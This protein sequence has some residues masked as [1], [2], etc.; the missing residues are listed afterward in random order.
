[1]IRLELAL[2]SKRRRGQPTIQLEFEDE[3][4]DHAGPICLRLAKPWLESGRALGADSHFM[5]VESCT[6]MTDYV[7]GPSAHMPNA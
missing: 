3:Y 1:M 5:S 7:R 6:A 4:H 2:K